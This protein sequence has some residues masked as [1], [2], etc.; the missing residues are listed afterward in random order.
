MWSESVDIHIYVRCVFVHVC[1]K[2]WL[3]GVHMHIREFNIDS[4]MAERAV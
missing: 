2:F 1:L 3:V 4:S